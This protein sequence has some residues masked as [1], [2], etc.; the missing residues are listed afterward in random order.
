MLKSPRL[1]SLECA[2][3]EAT[4]RV[5]RE[6]CKEA[7]RVFRRRDDLRKAP[8]TEL[9]RGRGRVEL[10]EGVEK[11]GE[12]GSS[13]LECRDW[14][15]RGGGE[16]EFGRDMMTLEYASRIVAIIGV[17]AF[18][19]LLFTFGIEL[20]RGREW[21]VLLRGSRCLHAKTCYRKIP[22]R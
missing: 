8:E 12:L 9:G 5:R 17:C 7:W 19:E 4:D 3:E 6:R 11:A 1:P 14:K 18:S 13:G 15:G 10:K 2:A 22:C 16:G 20:Y 21:K